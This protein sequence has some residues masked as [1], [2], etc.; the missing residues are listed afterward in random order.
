MKKTFTL[1]LAIFT[2]QSFAQQGD[3]WKKTYK[4]SV[5]LK[6]INKVSF[7][8]PNIE[9]LKAEDALV[10]G[11]G[12]APWRFGWNNYTN[13]NTSNAGTWTTLPN[14]DRLWQLLIECENAQTINLTFAQT[15]IPSGNQ[16][17]VFNPK[18]DLIL[19]SFTAN[20][21]F[22]G[23][24][25]AELISGSQT[26]VE[27]FV[28]KNNP[29]GHIQISTVTHGYRTAID[30]QEKAFGS[31]GSCNRNV[32]CSEG[33]PWTLE[34]NAA[35]MLVSGSNGF[36]S[37]SLINN[38]LNDSKPYVLTADHCYS[39]PAS[40]IFRF[41]WQATDCNNPA[42]SP[43]FQSL[44]GAAL[45]ARASASDFCLVEITGGL[46]AGTVPASYTPYFSGW[47]H[48]GNT[49]T[50]AVGI[51][52][53]SG[54]IKKI[55]FENQPLISTTFGG[56]P[57]NSHWGVT[58]WDSG[59]TEGGSSGSP[60][61]DQNH[62]IIGQLHG[63][64]S[65]CG[66]T[67][68]SD[69]YGKI[70]YSWE[71]VGSNTTNQLKH[72][73]DPNNSGA[74][75]INGFDPS[76][77]TVA[78]LD[79]GLSSPL[80]ELTAFCGTNYTPKVTIANSGTSVLTSAV[81]T[82]SIDAG[83]NQTVNWSGSLAQWQTELI[84]LPS[85]MLAAGNH[86]FSA[87]VASPN[88]GIDENTFNDMT[89][90]SLTVN[91][92]D[93]TIGLLKVTL[94]TDNYPDETY[95][96]LTS[97]NGTVVWSEGN[98]SF[99]GNYGTGNSPAPTDPTAPLVANTTYNYDIPLSITDCYT[100]TIYDYYGDGLGAA[101]WGGSNID[102][103]LTLLN[104]TSAVLYTLSAPDFGAQVETIVKS[105]DDSGI[106]EFGTAQWN[107]FPNPVKDVLNVTI[108]NGQA[109]EWLIVD[110]YGK[111]I[112]RQEVQG[113]QVQLNTQ[114]LSN[115]TYFVRV[116]FVNGSTSVKSFVKQ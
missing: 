90:T 3:G 29:Q 25:G 37:G 39:N 75:F 78:A 66:A 105:T 64:A 68:L 76:N 36:C 92:I 110:V 28:P 32:N 53:P 35:V 7:Q 38:T 99:V 52:H 73:L 8:E 80:L 114:N 41:N 49:P 83:A 23:Q 89:N 112:L 65:A 94:L 9:T 2:F 77:A 22:D 84:T 104:H 16:L 46:S 113:N 60:L 34:R 15:E 61:Y 31:S 87:S 107:L 97:S 50:S 70:S 20:H 74:E 14:G 71:P 103:N 62:R 42:T 116:N 98:E 43:T 86:T 111:T 109:N 101:Q 106:D 4:S 26:I 85:V 21:L 11:T 30:F 6:Q 100:F 102:G 10:D 88:A 44:S 58:Y 91:A 55:S 96:E 67:N 13:L 17:Y 19:G 12:T 48:S 33:L 57:A 18:K 115:G 93:E 63:G 81:V 95:M 45:R 54:D 40:W 69:E 5:N 51:H 24:L 79:A 56:S 82:Y 59:V 1:L 47:D 27:Y 72:W 108:Q